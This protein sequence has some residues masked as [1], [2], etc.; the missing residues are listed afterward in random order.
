[1]T[2]PVWEALPPPP[3]TPLLAVTLSVVDKDLDGEL[4]WVEDPHRVTDTVPD[5]V[6]VKKVG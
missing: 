1:M 3:T 5:M 4:V 6:Y 2:D